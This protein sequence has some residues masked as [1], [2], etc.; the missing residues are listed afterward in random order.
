MYLDIDYEQIVKEDLQ[1]T[2]RISC[3]AK[4]IVALLQL[5]RDLQ[6]NSLFIMFLFLQMAYFCTEISG[7]KHDSHGKTNELGNLFSCHFSLAD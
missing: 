3:V 1:L 2:N 6:A 4:D 7:I 5:R